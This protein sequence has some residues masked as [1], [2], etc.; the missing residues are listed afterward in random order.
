MSMETEVW[1]LTGRVQTGGRTHAVSCPV[2]KGIKAATTL[3]SPLT[4]TFWSGSRRTCCQSRTRSYGTGIA[5]LWLEV[6][7]FGTD[8]CCSA[9]S[10][11]NLDKETAYPLVRRGGYLFELLATKWVVIRNCSTHTA[12]YV[13]CL[14]LQVNLLLRVWLHRAFV[15]ACDSDDGRRPKKTIFTYV[16]SSFTILFQ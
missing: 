1:F 6:A 14:Q 9:S 2:G 3:S 12:G 11:G 7:T 16:L 5:L 4:S 13:L 8:T 10:W 15:S